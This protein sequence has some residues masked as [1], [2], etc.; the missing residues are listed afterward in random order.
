MDKLKLRTTL[1]LNIILFNSIF[2][3]LI[4]QENT[5]NNCENLMTSEYVSDGKNYTAKLNNNNKAVFYTT[6]YGESSYRIIACSDMQQYKHHIQVFD[7]ER[8]LLFDNKN[9]DY[10]PY[11]N[12]TFKS[13]INCIIE[14]SIPSDILLNKE[15]LLLIGFKEK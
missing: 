7:T 11:W 6:F 9:Y 1:I 8:N 10:I 15:V 4:A 13:T 2:S 3:F 5:I 14:I 12:F